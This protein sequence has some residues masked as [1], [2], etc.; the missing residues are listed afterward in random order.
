V[1]RRSRRPACARIAHRHASRHHVEL[2]IEQ[3]C[4]IA[5]EDRALRRPDRF[6][7]RR[8]AELLLSSGISCRRSASIHW[9][10]PNHNESVP[11]NTWSAPSPLTK[12]AIITVAAIREACTKF[13]ASNEIF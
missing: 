3:A 9:G 6:V 8:K 7:E 10:E 5:A 11:Y 13:C 4:G 2:E 12:V 1:A